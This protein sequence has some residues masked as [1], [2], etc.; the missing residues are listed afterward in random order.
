MSHNIIIHPVDS[1]PSECTPREAI[2][3]TWI[4]AD[5]E[6][7]TAYSKPKVPAT[8]RHMDLDEA[9]ELMMRLKERAEKTHSKPFIGSVE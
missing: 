1:D 5:D 6:P 4:N 2:E 7:C 3:Y 8:A 9:S